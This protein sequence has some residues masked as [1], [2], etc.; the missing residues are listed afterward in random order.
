MQVHNG[1]LSIGHKPGGKLYFEAMKQAGVTIVLTLLQEHEGAEY[2]GKK[3]AA[4]RIEWL[5]FPF[6]AS[7]PLD[8]EEKVKVYSLFSNLKELLKAGERIYIH[9]SAGI[10]RTGM[11]TYGLLR[12]LG[13]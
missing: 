6:S 12:Y 11:I 8:G 7:K 5:W 4:I 9:C 10:H 2:I 13:K 1:F 3:A